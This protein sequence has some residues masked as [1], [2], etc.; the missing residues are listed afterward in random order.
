MDASRFDYLTRSLTD[1]PS[2]RGLLRGLSAAALGLA[3]I[4]IPD[5][6]GA[7]KKRK[8]K[9]VRNA[10][11][12]VD[13][14][15]KC[16]GKDANCCSGICQGKKPK[17]GKKDTSTCVAHNE[18]ECQAGQDSCLET[19]VLCGEFGDCFST[20]GKAG[21]CG[22][23]ADCVVCQKDADCEPIKGQGAACVVCAVC[24]GTGTA[25]V[26]AV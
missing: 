18:G 24:A 4:R 25:C 21:F 12:C 22:A 9:V 20:T 15:G 10:F 2:R 6:V 26:L 3:A 19:D 11:G 17:Q 1:M 23:D 14:G 5:G 13:V 16:R 7:K 8:K